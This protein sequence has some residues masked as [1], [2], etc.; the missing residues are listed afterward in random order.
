VRTPQEALARLARLPEGAEGVGVTLLRANTGV[1]LV[2][3]LRT[4]RAARAEQPSTALGDCPHPVPVCLMRQAVFPVSS[5]DPVA[6]ATR[7]G[8]SLLV[9]N[10]HVVGDLMAAEVLTP[11]GPLRGRVVPSD[12]PGDLVL[13]EVEGLPISGHIPSPSGGEIARDGP[14]YA[15]GADIGRQEVRVFDPG[16]VL[17]L[18]AEGAPLGRLHVTARMQPGVS[19][20]AV[21][22]ATGGLLGIAVGGGDG[23]FE[24]IPNAQIAMLLSGRASVSAPKV[25]EALG[26]AFV[27]CAGG[28]ADATGVDTTELEAVCMA[29]ANHGQLLEAGR[30]LAR[31]GAYDGAAALHALALAQTP[32]S[33][34]AR[35]SLLVSLQLGARFEDMIVHAR[36]LMRIAPQDPQVLRFA[37][38]SGVWGSAPDLAEDAYRIL[39]EVDPR[40]SDACLLYTSPSPRDRTRSRMPSPA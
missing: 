19:G 16:G 12:Y 14:V 26:D 5:F 15:I 39:R 10:R 36:W 34:N 1:R 35:L 13:L 21:V 25:T 18:P 7:I 28:I 23:R 2:L 9:T 38:Q 27:Q 3:S 24:A 31:G 33:I 8:P 6:S 4:A 40:Q 20:G 29:A 11:D 37:I 32:N 17:A 22:D 30:V